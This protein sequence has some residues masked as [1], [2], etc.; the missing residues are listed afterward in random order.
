MDVATA[1]NKA[2]KGN[3]GAEEEWDVGVVYMSKRDG[4]S[5]S[6]SRRIRYHSQS[7]K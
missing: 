3:A 6:K 7:E 5:I 2:S 1:A 4:R